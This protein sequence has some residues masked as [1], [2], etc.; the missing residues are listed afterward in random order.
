MPGS[1]AAGTAAITRAEA[2]TS[3]RGALGELLGAERR[4]RARDQQRRDKLTYAQ[5]RAL[6]ALAESG[7]T[8]A[9]VSA[10]QLARAAD[11]H[12]ATVTAMLDLLEEEGVVTRRRSVT[13]RRSVLVALTPEGQALLERKRDEWHAQWDDVLE[14]IDAEDIATAARV[15]SRL[16]AVFTGL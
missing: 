2:I 15:M 3:A 6:L 13:D 16:A 12:P 4:L 14:D 8:D 5:A 9:D 7:G 10:G 11:L 1:A